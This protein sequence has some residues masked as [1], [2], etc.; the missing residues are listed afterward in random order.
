MAKRV[1]W[2]SKSQTPHCSTIHY[3]CEDTLE[4]DNGVA[5]ARLQSTWI[6][7]RVAS[8]PNK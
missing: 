5:Q 1:D 7:T 4:L 8:K 2:M 3:G 6:H